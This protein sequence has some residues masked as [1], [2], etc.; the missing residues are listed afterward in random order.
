MIWYLLQGLGYGG[1]A[2]AQPGPFQAYLLSQTLK[3][4]LRSTL[5]A[6]LAPLMSDGPIVLLVLLV[7]TQMP[8]W[9]VS[10]LRFAGGFFLIYL[11]Y[12]AYKSG[13]VAEGDTAVPTPQKKQSIREAALM[14]MLS[15]NAYIFWSTIAGPIFLEGWRQSPSHGLA[16]I[17][18]FYGAL[19]GGFMGF[20]VLFGVLGQASPK[21]NRWL[22]A[23]SAIALLGFGL[24]QIWLGASRFLL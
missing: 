20:V 9:F 5:V 19:I 10:A 7:L 21:L 17:F 3:N 22:G 16:F 23:I 18:G 6:A 14:N 15:P 2:A 24:Y 13:Q 4:G 12:K 1:A 8:D 11:A